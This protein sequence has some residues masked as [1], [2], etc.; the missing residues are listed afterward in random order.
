MSESAIFIAGTVVSVIVFTGG[1]IY[2]MLSVD[3]WGARKDGIT[4]SKRATS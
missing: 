4:D 3:R 1:F 2:A